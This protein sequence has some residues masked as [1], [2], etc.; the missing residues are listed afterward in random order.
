[1]VYP[2]FSFGQ[3]YFRENSIWRQSG[4]LHFNK[5]S[6]GREFSAAKFP[7]SPKTSGLRQQAK[8]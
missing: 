5:I 1:V 4:H 3:S 6:V 8:T 7:G 2:V